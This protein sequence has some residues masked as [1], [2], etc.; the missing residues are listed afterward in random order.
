[1]AA[2]RWRD[3]QRAVSA[4]LEVT[5]AFFF[6]F[7][8]SLT[9]PVP[10]LISRQPHPEGLRNR[11]LNTSASSDIQRVCDLVATTRDQISWISPHVRSIPFWGFLWVRLSEVG[12]SGNQPFSSHGREYCQLRR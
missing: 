11:H 4:S 8:L 5:P 7:P 12:L 1:M 3:N 9:L 2:K 10:Y 6:P